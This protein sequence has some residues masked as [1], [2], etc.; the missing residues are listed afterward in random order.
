MPC[1]IWS[2]P[3]RLACAIPTK[4]GDGTQ[5]NAR[6]NGFQRLVVDAET[7]FY[8]RAIVLDD[9][10]GGLHLLKISSPRACLRLSVRLRLLRCK[11]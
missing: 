10:I 2:N 8:V 5:N 3:G 7:M 9:N 11:F 4:A 6:V 1:A